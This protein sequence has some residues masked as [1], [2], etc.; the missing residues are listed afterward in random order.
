MKILLLDDDPRELVKIKN[1]F[2]SEFDLILCESLED[3]QRVQLK[4]EIIG[5]FL[6][7]HLGGDEHGGL[8]AL[9]FLKQKFPKSLFNML[10]YS[11]DEAEIFQCLEAGAFSF[12]SKPLSSEIAQQYTNH[13]LINIGHDDFK[14]WVGETL[15]SKECL[16]EI[17]QASK[18]DVPVFIS[19]SNKWLINKI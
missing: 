1:F 10:S 15:Q 12:L 19:R 9:Q 6:D 3:V 5:G 16:H 13:L 11:E 17:L 14:E 8:K 7:L 4:D 18:S 2:E